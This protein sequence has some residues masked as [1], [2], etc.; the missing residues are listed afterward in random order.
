MQ[1]CL[2]VPVWYNRGMIDGEADNM[3]YGGFLIR[4]KRL[5]KD[6]SQEG[7]C[8]G[9]CTASYLSKIEQGKAE[10]SETVLRMLLRRL[11]I[12]WC[13][14]G[15]GC[16]GEGMA[17]AYELL[18]SGERER[19]G[20]WMEQET[21][22]QYQYSPWGLDYQLID[23][24]FNHQQPLEK[25]LEGLMDARQ[26][27][28]Q[29][30][31]ED[32]P[33]EAVRLCPCAFTYEQGGITY[34][35]RGNM[36]QAIEFMH[37]ANALAGEEGRVRI[38]LQARITMGNC[39]ADLMD[40]P[41]MTRHYEAALRIARGLGEEDI[42]EDIAYNIA[43]TDLQMGRYEKALAYLE[44]T[45]ARPTMLSMHKLAIC[46][47]QLGQPENALEALGCC[48]GLKDRSPEKLESEMLRTV[49]LRLTDPNYLDSQKYGDAL[50]RSF[51][52]CRSHRAAGFCL[53]QLPWMLQWYEH[54]RQYKQVCRLLQEF[55]EYRK[56]SPLKE[57]K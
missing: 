8:K 21:W 4:E 26:L 28:L 23:R 53:F 14:E 32:R 39:Y 42:L 15:S 44:T 49:Y 7:L 9:I 38:M 56:I 33:E 19:L 50:H 12:P 40:V 20:A 54:H 25:E 6:W 13:G 36:A 11:G 5:E 57:E 2:F 43:A 18:L 41:L 24:L 31:L 3:N 16:T 47:E 48:K 10:P 46:Y 1:P 29:R 45:K 30:V 37:R 52:L 22:K 34:Y 35:E 17:E 27:A 55:P 51:S